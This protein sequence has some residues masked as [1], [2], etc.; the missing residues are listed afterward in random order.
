MME[1]AR[2]NQRSKVYALDRAILWQLNPRRLSKPE[3]RA[4]FKKVTRAI[5]AED[6]KLVYRRGGSRS[7]YRHRTLT[8]HIT[9]LDRNITVLLHELAHHLV[10]T[11]DVYT[12]REGSIEAHGPEFVA[13]YIALLAA[14]TDLTLGGLLDNAE[15]LK[16]KYR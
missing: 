2:D 11:R 14:F 3:F 15:E 5:G 10:G 6:V 8:I 12:G 13:E 7:Y 16:V 9:E 1:Y 4:L